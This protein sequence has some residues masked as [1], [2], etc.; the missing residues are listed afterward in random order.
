MDRQVMATGLR[1]AHRRPRR[2]TRAAVI[3]IAVSVVLPGASAGA[4]QAQVPFA[5]TG[6]E[7]PWSVP[8][9]VTRIHVIAVGGAGGLQG[10]LGAVATAD[11]GVVPG[12]TLYVNVGGSATAAQGGFNGGGDAGGPEAGGGGGASDV[13]SLSRTAADAQ[14]SLDSRLIVAGGGGGRGETGT[15]LFELGANVY[16]GGAGAEAGAQGGGCTAG[17]DAATGGG[18][19]AST[20]GGGGGATGGETGQAGAG[21]KGA[22]GVAAGGG[23]AGGLYG[24]GGGGEAA[25]PLSPAGCGAGGGGGSSGFAASAVNRSLVINSAGV[26]PAVEITYTVTP[27]PPVIT[28]TDPASPGSSAKPVVKGTLDGGAPT[29]IRVFTNATCAGE[30]AASGSAA[31]FTGPGIAV[32][33]AGGAS[34]PLSALAV[35]GGGS[36]GCSNS[37]TYVHAASQPPGSPPGSADEAAPALASLGVSPASFVAR[38]GTSV[39][40]HLSEAARVRFGVQRAVPGV[41]SRGRC[42]PLRGK[43]PAG[44]KRCTAYRVMKGSFS[45]VGEAGVNRVRFTGRLRGRSLAPGAYRLVAIARDAAGNGSRARQR[46]FRIIRR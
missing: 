5:A 7:Q 11:L 22:L 16:W 29:A 43:P 9:G 19:G 45:D 37:V 31:Q 46:T 6:A 44:A 26:A 10:G 30:P 23:G 24:G 34:T 38:R 18:P 20:M 42:L 3:G 28:G 4:V 25:V 17:A 1:R 35:N 14:A 2:T 12:S 33:V 13:R 41:R 36:S 8:A 27:D 21:G 15:E 39:V 40:Y 32:A